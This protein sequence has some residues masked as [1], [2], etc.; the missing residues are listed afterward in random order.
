MEKIIK[1]ISYEMVTGGKNLTVYWYVS[2][3]N[4][5]VVKL[6][7]KRDNRIVYFGS[8]LNLFQKIYIIKGA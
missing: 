1:I 5:I 6:F 3:V 7:N 2:M 8:L 4:C